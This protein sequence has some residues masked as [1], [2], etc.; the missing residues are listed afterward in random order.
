M[1]PAESQEVTSKAAATTKPTKTTMFSN[2]IEFW[3]KGSDLLAVTGLA[4]GGFVAVVA[5]IGWV[6]SWKAGTLKEAE[7]NRFKLE[8]KVSIANADSKAAEANRIAAK[9]NERA[10][11][12]EKEAAD[13]R[14]ELEK[15]KEKQAEWSLSDEQRTILFTRLNAAT[16]GKIDISY[17]VAEAERAAKFAKVLEGIFKESGYDL[18]PEIGMFGSSDNVEGVYLSFDRDDDKSRMLEYCQAFLDAG[19]P[20]KWFKRPSEGPRSEP[21]RDEYVDV[22]IKNKPKQ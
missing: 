12:L 11:S 4:F 18:F 2:S 13:A 9:A 15:L 19:I 10:A 8:S 22:L 1:K 5:I 6:F 14:L 16:K 17:T 21:W 20:A 3:S 7:L